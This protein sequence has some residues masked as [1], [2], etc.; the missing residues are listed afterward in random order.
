M[1][2]IQTGFATILSLV[3]VSA[4]QAAKDGP[5]FA[6]FV[7]KHNRHYKSADEYKKREQIWRG[8]RERVNRLNERSPMAFFADNFTSDF[9]DY[10]F[11]LFLGLQTDDFREE[12]RLMKAVH[13]EETR[14]AGLMLQG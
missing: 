11:A 14:D 9:D 13:D 6:S 10:E 12:Q 7:A 4:K 2:S 3:A 8:N 1:R 5:D